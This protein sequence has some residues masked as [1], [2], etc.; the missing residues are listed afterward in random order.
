MVVLELELVNIGIL[1]GMMSG[2]FG[3]GGGTITVPLLLALGIDI[4]H[5]IGISAFQMIFTSTYGSY[6]NYKKAVF[7]I[8]SNLPF[9]LGGA[10]GG[11][12]GGFLMSKS[13]PFWLAVILLFF[14]IATTIKIFVSAPVP[15]GNKIGSKPVYLLIGFAVGT[16]GGVVGIGGA[17]ILTPILMGYFNFSLKE[18]IGVSLFFVISSSIFSFLTIYSGGYVEISKAII[19]ALPSL[20][21]VWFGIYLAYKTSPEKHKSLLILLYILITAILAEKLIFGL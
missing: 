8:R 5:A 15:K 7:D 18:S 10:L 2:F 3:V 11:A 1:A 20:I 14:V 21:G 4:K 19:V 17:L 13:Q 6:L 12:F 9:L 16:I